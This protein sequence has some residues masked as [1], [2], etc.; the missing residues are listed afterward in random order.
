[1]DENRL[2]HFFFHSGSFRPFGRCGV[3]SGQAADHVSAALQSTE[4]INRLY[5]SAH[6]TKYIANVTRPFF[7]QKK[8]QS[9]PLQRTNMAMSIPIKKIKIKP[10]LSTVPRWGTA[11]QVSAVL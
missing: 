2:Q 1:M 11:N 10:E 8:N 6:R 9:A 7:E 4:P 3:T 5:L